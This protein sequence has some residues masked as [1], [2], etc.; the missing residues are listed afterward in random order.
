MAV[1]SLSGPLL[2]AGADIMSNSATQ[3]HPLGSYAE[4]SDGRGF[5]YCKVGAVATVPGKLYQSPAQD[6]TNLN[7][8]GGLSVAAAAIGATSVTITSSITLTAN[9]LAGGFLSVAVTPGQGYT[10]RIT[11][12]T[13]VT[14]AANAVI[15]L[16]DPIQVALTT[17]SKVLLV[18]HAYNGV[19]VNPATA[20]GTPVGVAVS[21]ITAGNFG[22]LQT[23]GICACLNDTGTAIGKGV[24]PSAAVAGAVITATGVYPTIGKCVNVGVTTEYDFIEL[25]IS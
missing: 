10:Y 23:R 9:Q 7:P 1:S 16:D 17:S 21:A 8:S 25:C 24:M 13:A 18:V 12:N 11:G 22:W 4:T 3:A 2:I 15:Y 20:S 5:R 19:I 14:G 6:T